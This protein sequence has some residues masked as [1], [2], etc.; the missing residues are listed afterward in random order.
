MTTLDR[1]VARWGIVACWMA[2]N[3]WLSDQP[4]VPMPH[5][6]DADKVL[7]TIEYGIFAFLLARAAFPR[8]R[9]IPAARRWAWVVLA[10]LLW[11]VGDEMHQAFVPGRS[12]DPWDAASDTAGGLL[13]ALAVYPFRRHRWAKRLGVD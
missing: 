9:R 8:L 1:P 12:C 3:I 4:H 2:I 13:V 11:G 7:H 5:F 10:C 6:Q